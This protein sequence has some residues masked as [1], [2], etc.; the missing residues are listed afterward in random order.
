LL[1]EK[2]NCVLEIGFWLFLFNGFC[3]YLLRLFKLLIDFGLTVF[4][5][6]LVTFEVAVCD[7]KPGLFHFQ[8][9][10]FLSE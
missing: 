6:L 5:D 9:K 2:G 8:R 3:D 1:L 4:Q 7:G 10:K